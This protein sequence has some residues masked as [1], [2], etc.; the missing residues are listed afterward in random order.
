MSY[1]VL[2]FFLFFD[3]LSDYRFS[4]GSTCQSFSFFRLGNLRSLNPRSRASLCCCPDYREGEGM[5]RQYNEGPIR[6][7]DIAKRQGISVR[8]LE[9]IIMKKARYIESARGPKGGHILTKPP[10]EITV[11]EMWRSWKAGISLVECVEAPALCDRTGIC[12]P[13]SSGKKSLR[14]S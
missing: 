4:M 9:Q 7:G 10:E 12:P 14:N 2:A 6:L 3:D 11:G 1:G 13:V 5:A 8:Y